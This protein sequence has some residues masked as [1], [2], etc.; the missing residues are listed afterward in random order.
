MIVDREAA[1]DL[2]IPVGTIAD[3]LRVL[4]GG[5][6]VSK[7]RDGDEQYDVWLRAEAQR[8]RRRPQDLYDLTLPSPTAGLVK[9]ASLAKLVDERGPDRDRAAQPRSGS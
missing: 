1:S 6:P 8:P 2:G 5:M 4:V 9:L 7:F 3:T